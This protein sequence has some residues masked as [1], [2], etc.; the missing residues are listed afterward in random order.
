MNRALRVGRSGAA[1]A[2]IALGVGIGAYNAWWVALCVSIPLVVV[3]L[4]L[5]PRS[6]RTSELDV[7]DTAPHDRSVPVR[8]EALTRSSLTDDDLQ[9]TL[10]TA[11]VSPPHDTAFQARWITPMAGD[12]FRSLTASPSIALAPD[13]LPARDLTRTPEFGDQPGKW[14]VIYPAVTVL[15]ALTVLF[16]VGDAWHISFD[17]PTSPPSRAADTGPESKDMNLNAR[18]DGMIRAIVEQFG[19]AAANNLLSLRFT[20]SGSD[21]GTVL[22]PTNG[23]TT[24]VY[25][26]NSGDAFTTPSAQVLRKDST[27]TAADIAS[28][29]LTAI[30]DKMAQQ[31]DA[32]GRRSDLETLEI[33]RSG[34]GAMVIV[35]GDF[36]G[37][38]ING[39]P[40]GTVGE[41]F[42]PADFAVS[43]QRARDALALAGIAPSDRVLTNFE[44]RGTHR[45]TPTAHASELQSSGGVMLEF[46]TGDRSGQIVIVPGE[47]P[48][49]TDTS[50]QS[51]SQPFAFDEISRDAFESVRTQA[52]QRGALEP[53]EREAVEIWMTDREIDQHRLAIR[54][55]LAGVEA[56]AGTYSVTGEFLTSGAT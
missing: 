42:D 6:T 7:F 37:K 14:A 41:I 8:V 33:K 44:I 49:V 10:V 36:G 13:R 51:R 50:Y 26:N 15:V 3:G 28:A 27:F 40:N 18:R 24:I 34:P 35:S 4:L 16:G 32:A 25:L 47:L 53:Y 56:A 19:P 52:M 22:D 48:E 45:A 55:E 1:G 54:I 11:T 17:R 5:V 23:D 38:T 31:L 29:D 2:V 46:H 20:G 12:H 39:L 21:Y 30:A 43:F 9:P